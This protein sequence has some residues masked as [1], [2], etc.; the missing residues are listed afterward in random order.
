M[1]LD[2]TSLAKAINQL[3]NALDAY[4]ELIQEKP[5]YKIY[6]RGAV[7][8]AFEFT[9]EMTLRMIKRH[10]GMTLFNPAE[11]ASMNFKDIVREAYKKN[12]IRSDVYYWDQY[13][14]N[15]GITSHTYN[16][17]KAQC[18]F[19]AASDFLLEAQYTLSS[20]QNAQA[21]SP[22]ITPKSARKNIEFEIKRLQSKL[23]DIDADSKK[24]K[25]SKVD[26]TTKNTR[27]ISRS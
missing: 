20:L 2:V 3:E 8:Q 16:E 18:V 23:R 14:K 9:Y 4:Y 27:K 10:L 15:R 22:P 25:N 7:I 26:T 21:D 12:L 24:T 17:E 11:V 13:R 19:E 1:S 6:M 5:K